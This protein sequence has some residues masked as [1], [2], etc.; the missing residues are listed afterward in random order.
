MLPWLVLIVGAMALHQP[1]SHV[2]ARRLRRECVR[3]AIHAASVATLI[4]WAKP[5]AWACSAFASLHV[6]DPILA[7]PA[8]ATAFYPGPGSYSDASLLTA[9]VWAEVIDCVVVKFIHITASI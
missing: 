9:L 3:I 5:Y 7:L 8:F 2:A 1:T 4:R 6:A